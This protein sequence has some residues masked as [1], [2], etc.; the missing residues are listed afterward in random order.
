VARARIDDEPFRVEGVAQHVGR[1]GRDAVQRLAV[2][3][4]EDD[5]LDDL[6]LADCS[7]P[8]V[9][10][11]LEALHAG[12]VV[13][14]AA[15]GTA[16]GQRPPLPPLGVVKEV[17]EVA[18][19]PVVDGRAAAL[20]EQ[21]AGEGEPVHEIG[22]RRRRG[23]TDQAQDEEL[24]SHRETSSLVWRWGANAR[25]KMAARGDTAAT[26]ARHR[27]DAAAAAQQDRGEQ[28]RPACTDLALL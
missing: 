3:V 8:L 22:R 26:P 21:V 7:R 18:D 4:L 17:G 25:A 6:E 16:V 11:H 24:Q 27:R 23:G 1:I 15:A 12:R 2:L 28:D 19:P 13:Q 9:D 10:V 5:R 14:R 20:V